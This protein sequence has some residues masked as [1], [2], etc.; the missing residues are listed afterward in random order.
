MGD[1]SELQP[2]T[3]TYLGPQDL[4][5]RVSSSRCCSLRCATHVPIVIFCATLYA[6]TYLMDGMMFAAW[7]KGKVG[8]A[9]GL[10]SELEL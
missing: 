1:H 7:P 10:C 9:R 3:C 8:A 6:M 2:G 5:F 4:C